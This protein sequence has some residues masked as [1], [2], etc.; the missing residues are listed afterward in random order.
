MNPSVALAPS[1]RHHHQRRCFY[2]QVTWLMLVLLVGLVGLSA[3]GCAG[4]ASAYEPRR[5]SDRKTALA[6]RLC[7]QAAPL[8]RSNT[9]KAEKLLRE[10]LVADLYHGPSHNNLGVVYLEQGMLF[11]AAG[12]F[13]WARRLMPGSPEPRMNLA[14]TLEQGGRTDDALD[15]YRT[16]LEVRPE[17]LPAI[18]GLTRLELRSNRESDETRSRLAQIALRGDPSWRDWARLHLARQDDGVAP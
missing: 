8:I 12:E 18:Q 13:E 10:A 14:L 3:G 1:T 17:H 15:A 11:E 6:D 5:E 2:S 7:H 16:A 4:T 9:A